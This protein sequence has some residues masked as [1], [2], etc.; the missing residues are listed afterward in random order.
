MPSRGKGP[1]ALSG[2]PAPRNNSMPWWTAGTGRSRELIQSTLI[3]GGG[4]RAQD[5]ERLNQFPRPH[6]RAKIPGSVLFPL[7]RE[8]AASCF[9]LTRVPPGIGQ[10][11]VIMIVKLIHSWAVC[12]RK[13]SGLGALA[14]GPGSKL[15][16]SPGPFYR[17]ELLSGVRAKG[18]PPGSYINFL[19]REQHLWAP[20]LLWDWQCSTHKASQDLCPGW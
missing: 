6:S 10:G 3:S 5:P 4:W 16:M 17:W 13:L 7:L 8:V 18:L 2:A 9:L 1:Q 20:V 15:L 11:V 19:S 12:S 14:S